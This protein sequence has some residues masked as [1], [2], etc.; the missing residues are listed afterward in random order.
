MSALVLGLLFAPFAP[1][2]QETPPAPYAALAER[3][4]ALPGLN[5]LI[6][7]HNGQP[8]AEHVFRGPPLDRA[9]N[10]KSASK[11]VISALVGIAIDRGVLEGPDQKIAPLLSASLPA[12]PDPRLHDIT[13][14]DLLTMRAGLER[15]SGANYGAW[16]S[17]RNW[18]RDALA[19]PFV[20]KPGG[21]M[22][23]ST[24][25]THL[26]SAI[27]TRA[28]GKSTHQLAREWLGDPL[29]IAIPAWERDPQGIYLGGNNMALSPR[30]LVRFGEMY[31]NG[32]RVDGKQVLSE[33]WIQASWTPVTQSF[34]TGHGYGYGWF[35]TDLA[36]H[37]A[38]YAWGYGGQM[39]YVVPDLGLTIAMTSNAGSYERGSGHVEALHRLVADIIIPE[40]KRLNVPP[41]PSGT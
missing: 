1:H 19:R 17:S 41:Q 38:N 31:R 16:I 3:G 4:K 14:A 29:D 2:A 33:A 9:V 27:L 7:S 37:R 28:S 34:F 21:R 10:I 35:S 40:T 5:A 13:I 8:V 20:D 25:S 39:L 15:T 22:L 12:N 26:L 36:G 18:V 11:S 32:G 24:G 30:A 23:Y 6:V